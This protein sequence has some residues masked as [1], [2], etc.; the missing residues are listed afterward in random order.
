MNLV[1]LVPNCGMADRIRAVST[2][3]T[4]NISFVVDGFGIAVR[5]AIVE[6]SQ[7]LN[8][9][10]LSPEKAMKR[11]A[12]REYGEANYLAGGIDAESS[13]CPAE[14]AQV[15]HAASALPQEGVLNL[16]C[17]YGPSDDL[18]FAIDPNGITRIASKCAQIDPSPTR[19]SATCVISNVVL[20]EAIAH[21]D[22]ILVNGITAGRVA[23]NCA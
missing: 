6:R 7:V 14:T 20:Q 18:I 21:N 4:H 5:A 22:A 1:R 19:D 9:A 3:I 16:A 15:M 2:C 13:A 23:A 8:A 12:T 10:A 11:R 17:R